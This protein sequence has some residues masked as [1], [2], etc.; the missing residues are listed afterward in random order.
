MQRLSNLWA[1]YWQTVVFFLI[2]LA[3]VLGD[4][5]SKVWIRSNLS[6]GDWLPEGAF[7]HLTHIRNTGAALGIFQN[8]TFPLTIASF[9]GVGIILVY[10]FVICRRFSFLNNMISKAG[11]A[12]I[13]GGTI[14][15]LIDRINLG[16]VTDFLGVGTFPA[17]NVADS[18]VTVGTA[19]FAGS[20]IYLVVKEKQGEIVISEKK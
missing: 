17:F 16:Y 6:L 15:N 19:V 20:L 3:V 9:V 1:K 7:F 12:S 8:H 13:L 11:L 10:A 5:F 14:G 2:A 4:Q 18:S